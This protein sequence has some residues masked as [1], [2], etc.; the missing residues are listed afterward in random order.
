MIAG[1]AKKTTP[2]SGSR[3]VVTVVTSSAKPF[4]VDSIR[5]PTSSVG[6]STS[7]KPTL[8]SLATPQKPLEVTKILS[9]STPLLKS[10]VQRSESR[11]TSPLTVARKALEVSYTKNTISVIPNVGVKGQTV[12]LSG[13][14]GQIPLSNGVP[15]S[16]H[17]HDV[18]LPPPSKRTCDG[19]E[20]HRP[21]S[22]PGPR[23]LTDSHAPLSVSGETPL[24]SIS[25]SSLDSESG[26]EQSNALGSNSSSSLTSTDSAPTSS[27]SDGAFVA[28][29]LPLIHS[30]NDSKMNQKGPETVPGDVNMTIGVT[31]ATVST[32]T[33]STQIH[34]TM[35]IPNSV[36]SS[37]TGPVLVLSGSAVVVS[38][39]GVNRSECALIGNKTG[40]MCR[41]GGCS[42]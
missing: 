41:W 16:N 30:K 7:S 40:P 19:L 35:S 28:T 10:A 20:T 9:S 25:K 1:L 22:S 18:Q 39:A 21:I 12:S 5:G 11:S 24:S 15:L 23:Q 4:N 3:D 42:R 17:V 8:A 13:N 37:R 36:P 2:T 26:S 27:R 32:T 29:D 6:L 14:K 34:D 33:T 31:T 38:S